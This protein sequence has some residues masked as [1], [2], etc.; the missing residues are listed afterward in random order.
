MFRG[1]SLS[2]GCSTS[3]RRDDASGDFNVLRSSRRHGSRF[4]PFHLTAHR[5]GPWVL[6]M[7]AINNDTS[8]AWIQGWQPAGLLFDHNVSTTTGV[9]S[10][11]SFLIPDGAVPVHSVLRAWVS[12]LTAGRADLL[13]WIDEY[14]IWESSEDWNLYYRWRRSTGDSG[15]LTSEP[16]HL[17]GIHES[18]DA[19]SLLLMARLF[20][21]GFR[22][23]ARDE[24]R[25]LRV[26]HDGHGVAVAA[27]K[28]V[29]ETSPWTSG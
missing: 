20:G 16:G 6:T 5:A 3:R 23:V 12:W 27:D 18:A 26:D 7:Q 9:L 19:V 4:A 11:H 28:A 10:R 24:R 13:V 17:F 29:M 25:A 2:G 21:W 14:G 8:A 1:R 15:L 22:A